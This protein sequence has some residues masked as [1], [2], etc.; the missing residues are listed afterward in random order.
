MTPCSCQ[1][2]ACPTR[3][4]HM[5]GVCEGASH[6]CAYALALPCRVLVVDTPVGLWQHQRLS[7]HWGVQAKWRGKSIQHCYFQV[8][9][10]S[11]LA[12][13]SHTT[14]HHSCAVVGFDAVHGCQN[15]GWKEI[16]T[17]TERERERL[18]LTS[19]RQERG[20]NSA[21]RTRSRDEIAIA[22]AIVIEATVIMLI[23]SG[24]WCWFTTDLR[25]LLHEVLPMFEWN[26][27]WRSDRYPKR[28]NPRS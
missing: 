7:D 17:E 10:H 15:A 9:C 4:L 3:R 14:R 6:L 13:L 27:L 26:F 22:I 28:R 1:P 8:A 16:E 20:K 12:R 2:C 24:C 18:K 11:C 25:S 19:F 23:V 21:S 5:F